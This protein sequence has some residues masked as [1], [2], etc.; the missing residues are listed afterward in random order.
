LGSG[1][2]LAEDANRGKVDDVRSPLGDEYGEI[3]DSG[4]FRLSRDTD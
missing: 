4:G 1:H 3:F 2:S